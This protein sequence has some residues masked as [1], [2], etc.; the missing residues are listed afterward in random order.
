MGLPERTFM[1]LCTLRQ[2]FFKL[3][4]IEVFLCLNQKEHYQ[5]SSN[6]YIDLSDH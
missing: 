5:K 1:I 2:G 3:F 4:N 6:F